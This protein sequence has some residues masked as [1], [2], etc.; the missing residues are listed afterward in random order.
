LLAACATPASDRL[1]APER[2]GALPVRAEVKDVPF[3]PQTAYHCGPAALAMTLAYTGVEVTPEALAPAVF[4][5]GRRGTLQHDLVAGARRHGRLAVPL[6]SLEDVL[7][8][9]AAGRPVLVF[10]NLALDWWPQWHFAVARGYDLEAG[11]IRLHSGRREDI[12]T[13]L[14]TF[15][16]TWRRA[17]GWALAVLPPGELPAAELDE[18]TLL[19][20]AVGLERAERPE[21]ATQAYRAI[22]ERWPE[23]LAAWIGLGNASYAMGDL[24]TAE[25]AF[26]TALDHH[27]DSSAA[28][29]NLTHVRAER[30]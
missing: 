11:L 9:L 20:A 2:P 8:E 30:H 26:A 23:S 10:Q 5:P 19:E 29:Q 14:R 1:L 27:P 17:G 15:E 28:R 25:A 7:A 12:A 21:A 24:A 13:P 18:L 6:T 4:T 3:F 16:R 22:L